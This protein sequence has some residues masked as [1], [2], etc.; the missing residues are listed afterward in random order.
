[1]IVDVHTHIFPKFICDRRT[2]Y[3]GGE[4]AF[5]LLYESPKSKMVDAEALIESMDQNKVDVS[6][7]FGFPWKNP[8][9]CQRHNDY[10]LNAVAKHPRRLKGMC[11]VDM[12]DQGAFEEI[13]RCLN[14]GLSGVGEIAFYQSG[15]RPDAIKLL[16]PV[17]DLCRAKDLPVLI[18]TNEPIGHFYPGKTPVTLA[19]IYSVAETFPENKIIFA[20]WGGGIFFYFL[21]KKQVRQ[22]MKNVFFDTAASPFL[23]DPKIY[24][25]AIETA[26]ADK[27]LLGTDFPLIKPDRY[28]KEIEQAGLT[29]N[30]KNL[31]FGGN[32]AELFNL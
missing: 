8:D 12:Y 18:H 25:A 13:K 17:M 31:I 6:V 3:F 1:M 16:H 19:Q 15:I 28:Y 14:G 21:L 23:Y 27:I 4:P 5:K 24:R 32:A 20:H 10:I 29:E 22:T 2:D 11:C 9:T 7:A 30:E 26:G